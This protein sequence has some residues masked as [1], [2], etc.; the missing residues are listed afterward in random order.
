MLVG[1]PLVGVGLSL[2][3]LKKGEWNWA[4]HLK[5]TTG[6]GGGG[7]GGGGNA[8]STSKVSRG[9]HTVLGTN[10]PT[11]VANKLSPRTA[12]RIS[13]RERDAPAGGA[14]AATSTSGAE[15]DRGSLSSSGLTVELAET[16]TDVARRKRGA[17]TTST[18]IIH[19]ETEASRH[20]DPALFGGSLRGPSPTLSKSK[21][22]GEDHLRDVKNHVDRMKIIPTFLQVYYAT[23]K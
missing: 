22:F 6:G 15:D 4:T 1:A 13:Q 16:P 20:V 12:R 7:G 2:A 21:Q 19:L 5:Y 10:S 17:H 8:G 3:L 18:R 9:H 23:Y 14:D 11:H